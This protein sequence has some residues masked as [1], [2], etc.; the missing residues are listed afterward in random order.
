MLVEPSDGSKDGLATNGNSDLMKR[1]LTLAVGVIAG[2]HL[3]GGF[4]PISANWGIHALGFFP[5]ELKI[6]VPLLMLFLIVPR[7]QSI[8][9]GLMEKIVVMMGGPK[10][11]HT[12]V[13]IF[14]GATV[15]LGS[16]FWV[17]QERTYL[18]GDGE[19]L[20]RLLP[21]LKATEELPTFFRNEPLSG[22][23][24]WKV[25]TALLSLGVPGGDVVSVQMVS[26]FFGI[27]TVFLMW[28]LA[29]RLSDA[30]PV[31]HLM[32]F[33]MIFFASTTQLFFGYVEVY[34]PLA[35]LTVLFL[36][37]MIDHLNQGRHLIFPSIVFGAMFAMHFGTLAFSPVLLYTIFRS[38]RKGN[39]LEGL[40]STLASIGT[41]IGLLW[42]C[43]YSMESVASIV[44]SGE[45]HLIPLT[46]SSADEAYSL[47]S[48]G[49]LVNIVNLQ[50]LIAPL[51]LVSLILSFSI[52]RATISDRDNIWFVIL[53]TS[54]CGLVVS[55]F[56]KSGIG[57]SRDWDLFAV[58]N[59]GIVIA[60]A[61]A[62][63]RMVNLHSDS[64]RKMMVMI[65]GVTFLHTACWIGLNASE[66]RAVARFEILPDRQ[67]WN[68]QGMLSTYEELSIFYRAHEDAKRAVF[69]L[70]RYLAI[71][72]SNPRIWGSLANIYRL[73]G[74]QQNEMLNYE[75]AIAH[76]SAVPEIYS[77]LGNIYLMRSRFSETIAIM[78]KALEL[79]PRSADAYYAIGF[80]L[81]NEKKEDER[82]L[83]YFLQTIAIDSMYTEAY[84]GA[85]VCY[86]HL[87]QVERMKLF[88]SKYLELDPHSPS[89][90]T[91]Q[92]IL[93]ASR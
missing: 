81:L 26:I 35:C 8:L 47:F 70:E 55:V 17:G 14:I 91:V 64:L 59:I 93:Q 61:F 37:L 41:A 3:F 7:V 20:L 71:D 36:L 39:W 63:V 60:S 75:K 51:G 11:R 88:F 72:S 69:Y 67:L 73:A 80:V 40:Q 5:L 86:N 45:S 50:L 82:A 29:R 2:L 74:D 65:I 21:K 92:R 12:R 90:A 44:L 79:N 52:H 54:M 87:K 1:T 85:G 23:I 68:T 58:F 13:L 76:G 53:L 19:L 16:L 83:P 27:V 31:E 77:N 66:S 42:I 15:L 33:L 62:W 10:R 43:G 30:R 34:T 4:T 84:L 24:I 57:M 25:Y 6:L 89:A 18:L 38:V 46:P 28:S 9:V 49:H 22:F 32:V 78:N 56:F 48:L